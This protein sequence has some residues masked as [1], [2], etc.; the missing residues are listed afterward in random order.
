MELILVL[1]GALLFAGTHI[2]I[3]STGLRMQW[4]GRFGQQAYL[5]IYSLI[6][7]ATIGVLIWAYARSFHGPAIWP[8]QSWLPEVVMPV[9]LFFIVGGFTVPNPTSVG[10]EA[11]IGGDAARGMLRIT[12]HPVMWG[13]LLWALTHLIA[14]GDLPSLIFFAAFAIVAGVGMISIDHRKSVSPEWLAFANVTSLIPFAAIATGRNRLIPS[15]LLLPAVIAIV[16]YVAMLWGHPW[17]SG[18]I[19]LL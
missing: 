16:L 9:A 17:L 13:F 11:R 10:A 15:E 3:S 19:A 6:S 5:G 1:V 7:F 14:N 18:G 8:T 4:I 2:G 12:R